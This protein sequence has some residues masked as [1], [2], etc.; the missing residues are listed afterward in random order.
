MRALLAA[1]A[2]LALA[3]TAHTAAWAS[4]DKPQGWAQCRG[5]VADPGI[6]PACA[7][8]VS[9]ECVEVRADSGDTAWVA[10]LNARAVAWEA[11]LVSISNDLRARNNPA[12]ESAALARWMASRASRCQRASE[13]ERMTQQYGE[14]LAAAA[15]F[16]CVL[17]SNIEEAMR[18]ED[19][20]NGG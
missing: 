20:A 1:L 11:Y 13:I 7:E 10:C 17:G 6:W 12:G 2:A 5:L 4:E 8:A 15:V 16:Q 9:R 19:I 3:A 18:L 14:T